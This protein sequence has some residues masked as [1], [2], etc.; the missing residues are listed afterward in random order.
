[1]FVSHQVMQVCMW[2]IKRIE[3]NPRIGAHCRIASRQI[4]DLLPHPRAFVSPKLLLFKT[5]SFFFIYEFDIDSGVLF[6]CI[7]I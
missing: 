1:M 4:K 6:V 2:P 3:G 5:I 7:T